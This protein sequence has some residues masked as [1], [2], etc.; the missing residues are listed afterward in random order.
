MCQNRRFL[1]STAIRVAVHR[2]SHRGGWYAIKDSIP[3]DHARVT[4][5]EFDFDTIRRH[6]QDRFEP[7]LKTLEESQVLEAVTC[8]RK[9]T[10]MQ[11]ASKFF[12]V[13]KSNLKL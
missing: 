2:N 12:C 11:A 5:T 6:T 8:S 13:L 10:F 9:N 7:L 3:Q 1:E 4:T